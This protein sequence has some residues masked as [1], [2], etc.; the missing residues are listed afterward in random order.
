MDGQLIVEGKLTLSC[1]LGGKAG[2]CSGLAIR[3]LSQEDNSAA[4]IWID[5]RL[6]KCFQ[7]EL[8]ELRFA[9]PPIPGNKTTVESLSDV[10]SNRDSLAGPA[11]RS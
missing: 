4:L 5:C 10:N 2:D 7:A 6:P 11:T 8:F 3:D 1:S 9:L